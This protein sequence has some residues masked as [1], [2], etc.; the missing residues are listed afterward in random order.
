M[1]K[2]KV[3]VQSDPNTFTISTNMIGIGKG[4]MHMK[5]TIIRVLHQK[6]PHATQAQRE[7]FVEDCLKNGSIKEAG[8]VNGV[9][10]YSI[11]REYSAE[12]KKN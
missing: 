6:C 4:V 5:T 3:K 8:S 10:L 7:R 1:A 11:D 9:P 2:N 12:L